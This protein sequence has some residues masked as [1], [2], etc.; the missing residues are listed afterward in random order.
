M[1]YSS[2]NTLTKTLTIL[3][4]IINYYLKSTSSTL[5]LWITTKRG[6]PQIL[7]HRGAHVW[8]VKLFKCSPA[9][10]GSMQLN[11]HFINYNVHNEL[12]Y[13]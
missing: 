2:D 5:V 7:A 12:E 8:I 13:S 1:D 10:L 4:Y 9:A 3:M 6:I 11:G